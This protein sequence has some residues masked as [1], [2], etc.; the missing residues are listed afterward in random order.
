MGDDGDFIKADESTIMV[1][2]K[3]EPETYMGDCGK[4][5]GITNAQDREVSYEC[6]CYLDDNS[7]SQAVTAAANSQLKTFQQSGATDGRGFAA[8]LPLV[9]YDPAEIP[10]SKGEIIKTTFKSRVCLG[11]A[12]E[13]SIKLAF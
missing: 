12:G 3:T 11:S 9:Q 10:D 5:K 1:D 6:L 8:Y 4:S 13:D 7:V 2:E